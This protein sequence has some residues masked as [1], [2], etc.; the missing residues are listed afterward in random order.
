[1]ST[2]EL[3]IFLGW[4]HS[5][6]HSTFCNLT[7]ISRPSE[8]KSGELC[9]EE[10]LCGVILSDGQTRQWPDIGVFASLLF[11]FVG[12]SEES[13]GWLKLQRLFS[14]RT[15]SSADRW[16]WPSY[17]LSTF[18]EGGGVLERKKA[19]VKWRRFNIPLGNLMFSKKLLTQIPLLPPQVL[20]PRVIG[21][22]F[23]V[24]LAFFFYIT[25]IP[26]RFF[27]GKVD[28]LGHSHNLWHI[29]IVIALYY[30]H[31]TG[32]NYEKTVDVC[33]LFWSGL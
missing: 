22:Y 2:F 6:D 18:S 3:L 14:N 20:V 29:I 4:T 10:V 19:K 32:K 16:H 30:W 31:N 17:Q 28:Y 24:G 11:G 25:R 21:M 26:E 23:L 13:D 12:R 5:L 27:N 33:E 8:S 1:M 9:N 7:F 15:W